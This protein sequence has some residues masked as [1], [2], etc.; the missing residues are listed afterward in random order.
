VDV[1][2]FVPLVL[3]A[4]ER[5]LATVTRDLD[6]LRLEKEAFAA[7]PSQSIDYAVMEKTK[8]GAVVRADIGWSDVCSWSALWDIGEKDA[9]GNVT[10][11]DV[12]AHEANGCYLWAGS[13]LVYA[14]GVK[15][16][17]VVDTDDALLIADRS[18]APEVKDM[19]ER[20]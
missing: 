2:S 3:E 4:A 14:L 13:H 8:R 16:L 19:V 17:L 15:D 12:Q 11:G 20:P 18:R 9:A 6:F 10:R 5:A 1:R 7:S